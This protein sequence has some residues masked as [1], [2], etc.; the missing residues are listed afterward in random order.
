MYGSLF[1][2]KLIGILPLE[3]A[4]ISSGN[5]SSRQSSTDNPWNALRDSSP[6]WSSSPWGTA[7]LDA[8]DR[9]TPSSLNSLLPGDLLG[10]ESA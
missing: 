9:A 3:F 10:G 4:G 1:V 6:L 8:P 2:V 7:G 5:N